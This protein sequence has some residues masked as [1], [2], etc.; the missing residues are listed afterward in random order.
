MSKIDK[1]GAG[2]VPNENVKESATAPASAEDVSQFND[3]LKAAAGK[4]GGSGVHAAAKGTKS[5]NQMLRTLQN[6]LKGLLHAAAAGADKGAEIKDTQQKI[7]ELKAQLSND[8][9]ES[10]MLFMAQEMYR[11]V[12]DPP[13]VYEDDENQN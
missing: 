12:T 6:K 4:V 7:D 10:T 8:M 9:Q 3:A 5:I 2:K 11:Q 1:T 13:K